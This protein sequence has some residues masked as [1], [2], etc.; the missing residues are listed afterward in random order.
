MWR[1]SLQTNVG[2]NVTTLPGASN[3][4]LSFK[5]ND[6]RPELAFDLELEHDD[7]YRLAEALEQYVPLCRGYRLEQQADLST[8]AVVRYAGVLAPFEEGAESNTLAVTFRG[9]LERLDVPLDELFARDFMDAGDIAADLLATA[10]LMWPTGI[11]LGDVEPTV[12]RDVTYDPGKLVSDAIAELSNMS[13]GY[14]FDIEPLNDGDV[15]GRLHIYG[16][17]GQDRPAAKFGYGEGTV[18]NCSDARRKTTRPANRVVVF[19]DEGLQV[20]VDDPASQDRYGMW[21]EQDSLSDELNL[22]NLEARALELLRPTFGRVVEFDPDP[23]AGNCPRP[24]T[25]FWLGDTVRLD[26]RKGALV[27]DS[28]EPRIDAITVDVDD[29]G[30]EA[31]YTLQISDPVEAAA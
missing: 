29:D 20:V 2:A 7:A 17:Q 16:D 18:G 4:R 30:N 6:G 3:R 27:V 23:F 21:V 8:V 24:W 22:A 19:G 11:E 12:P 15:I 1:W 31:G 5:R 13:D 10:D 26:V 28:A 25:D 14:D 9:G